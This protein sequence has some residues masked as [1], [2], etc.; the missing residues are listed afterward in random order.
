MLRTPPKDEIISTDET[1]LERLSS[2]NHPK[3]INLIKPH[4]VNKKYKRKKK[5]PKISFTLSVI[6]IIT[7][8]VFIINFIR[9]V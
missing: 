5:F 8:I 3:N 2:F 4:N 1:E 7:G 9:F 6:F